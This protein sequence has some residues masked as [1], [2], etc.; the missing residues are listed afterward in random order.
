MHKKNFAIFTRAIITKPELNVFDSHCY[1]STLERAR[2][3]GRM[4]RDEH[5]Y[6]AGYAFKD[7]TIY[8]MQIDPP[9]LIELERY[10]T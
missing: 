6:P 10:E 8:R 9:K 1:A 3:I 2:E 5:W 7:T 4:A